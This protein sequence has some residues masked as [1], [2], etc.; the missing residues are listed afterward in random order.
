VTSFEGRLGTRPPK[1]TPGGI[2]RDPE[3]ID[4][5]SSGC[6]DYTEHSVL[7]GSILRA[8][9]RSFTRW[10]WTVKQFLLIPVPSIDAKEDLYF[11]PGLGGLTPLP[12][13]VVTGPPA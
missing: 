1:S 9:V 13:G 11:L 6:Q 5:E 4:T 3:K 2:G 12:R 7:S 10:S 8:N